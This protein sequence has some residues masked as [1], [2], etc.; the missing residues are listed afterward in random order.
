MILNVIC[1]LTL[2]ENCAKKES[3]LISHCGSFDHHVMQSLNDYYYYFILFSYFN[4]KNLGACNIPLLRCFQDLFTGIL[5]VPE[6]LK[7]QLVN[8]IY[9]YTYTCMYVM[10]SRMQ[11]KLVKRTTMGNDCDFFLHSVLLV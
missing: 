9:I 7:F 5:Y 4:F 8:H 1:A 11:S 3:Q 6:F 2:V 10:A